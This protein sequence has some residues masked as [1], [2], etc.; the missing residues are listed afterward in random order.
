MLKKIYTELLAY[1]YLGF[2]LHLTIIGVISVVATTLDG[3]INEPYELPLTFVAT[4]ALC[5]LLEAYA[6]KPAPP[7]PPRCSCSCG[8][9]Q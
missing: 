3:T 8:P 2:L 4:V 5:A 1:N 6:K 9:D 7:A